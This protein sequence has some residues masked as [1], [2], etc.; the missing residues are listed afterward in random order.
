MEVFYSV[1][2]VYFD[3][4]LG[5]T[6]SNRWS[7]YVFS[8]FVFSIQARIAQ[9]VAYQLGAEEA[10]GLNPGKG[11]NFSVILLLKMCFYANKTFDQC[12]GT[13][14]KNMFFC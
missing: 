4:N 11:K 14:S 13:N 9:T 1:S 7:K 10:P 6:S 5:A 12:L 2:V 3:Q 8:M